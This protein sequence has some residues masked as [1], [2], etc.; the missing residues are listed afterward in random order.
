[1]HSNAAFGETLVVNFATYTNL[2]FFTLLDGLEVEQAVQIS[3]RNQFGSGNA[4]RSELRIKDKSF[5]LDAAPLAQFDH[6]VVVLSDI[7]QLVEL[8]QLRTRMIRIASHD[9][10]NPLST[11]IGYTDLVQKFHEN[12]LS[13]QTREFL[14]SV[15][16]ALNDIN[17]ITSDILDLEQL[18]SGVHKR[19][20]LD[21]ALLAREVF[22]RHAP[23]AA[24]KS[25]EYMSSIAGHPVYVEGD[26]R[27]LSQALSNLITNAIKYT[28]EAGRISVRLR[29]IESH[30]GFEV[31][32]TGYGISKEAQ[33]K[34]FTEFYRVRTEKTSDIPGTG[35][36]LSLVK[37][38]V[39]A[40]NGRVWLESE[41]GKGS[42]FFIELP[43]FS[44]QVATAEGGAH[45]P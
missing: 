11:A 41:D 44:Q 45:G 30:V 27:Q 34:L 16:R 37:S 38:I 12:E 19:D 29:E 35:L 15:M 10:K 17:R 13:E 22:A 18:R 8:N 7:T 2:S 25:Q 42:K 20:K 21:V 32:D 6:W 33:D 14:S 36:G 26:H 31:E 9:L 1:M 5:Y 40:H 43:L 24:G 4:F 39:E 28:P 3:V 23:D